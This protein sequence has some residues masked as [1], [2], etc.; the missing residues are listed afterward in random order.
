M[1]DRIAELRQLADDL[2]KMLAHTTN[3]PVLRH[4]ANEL[5]AIAGAL[6]AGGAVVDGYVVVPL[7]DDVAGVPIPP[8][9]ALEEGQRACA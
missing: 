6:D 3:A 8:P 2:R 7:G 1:S 5:A 9:P 4:A